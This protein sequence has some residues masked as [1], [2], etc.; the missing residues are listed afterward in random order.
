MSKAFDGTVTA[1]QAL[2]TVTQERYQIELQLAQQLADA[3]KTTS[4]MFEDSIR[5]VKLD[6]LDAPGKYDFYD[7][8]SARYR[9]VLMTLTDPAM[10]QEYA[11]RLNSNIMAAWGVLTDE[12]KKDTSD[13][14]VKLL[15][16]SDQLALSRYAAVK[17]TTKSD[18]EQ[19]KADIA[20]AVSAAVSKIAAAASIPQKV[21]VS[22]AIPGIASVSEVVAY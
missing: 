6:V 19:L 5:S 7:K 14:F 15:E 8:E 9:D 11:G 17:E 20:A 3:V 18:N 13:K 21:E 1:A 12:Q 22:V 10:I 4:T 2:A 16:D